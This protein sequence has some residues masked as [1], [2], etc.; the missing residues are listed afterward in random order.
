[1]KWTPIN[2]CGR[3]CV[4]AALTGAMLFSLIPAAA[5]ESYE[6]A[7]PAA[8]RSSAEYVTADWKFG[9]AYTSGSIAGGDLIIEDQSGNEND[10]KMQTYGEGDWS[11]YLSF[12]EESMTGRDGSMVFDGDTGTKTGA[13]F[14]TVDGAP[15]NGETFETGYTIEVLY[16]FPEDWTAAD[17]WMGILARQTDDP[18]SFEGMDEPELGTM[19]MAVSNC[20]EIQ[21][22][23]APA[24]QGHTMSSAAWS[25]TMD[26]GGV[27]YHIAVVSDGHE[28]S[29]YVNGCEAFRDYASDEMA[30]MY[31]DPEDGR[32]RV[33][34]SWWN[35]LDKFL[36]GSLQ[37]IRISSRALDKADWL[38]PNPED[39]LGEFGRND[40]YQLRNEDN[41]NYTNL[42]FYANPIWVSVGE[43]GT[44]D[45]FAAESLTL[46]PGETEASVNLNWYAPAGT[47]SAQVKFGEQVVDAAVSELT[48]PTKVDTA[49][50]TDTGKMACKATVSGLTPETTYQ[51]QISND[52]GATW[53]KVYTYTTAA[54]DS[55]TFA[56]TSDP[57][58]KEDQST[59][60]GG[61]NPAD[62]TNQTGWAVMM[63]TVAEAGASLMVSAGDQ[64][65]DQSWGKS[66]EYAAFFAPEEMTSMLY[67]PAVG[68]HDRHYMFADHFNLPNEMDVAGDGQPGTPSLLEQIKTTFRGQNNGTS[69]SHGN[70][71]QATADEIANHSESNGVTPNAQGF[72]DFTERRAMETRGNYYYLFNNVL[73]VTLNTGA[74]PG[75]NDEENAGNADVPSAGKDNAEAEAMVENFRRTLEAAV[76]EYAGQYDWL[77]VTHH[78]STQTVAKHAA[79]SDIEN[80]VDAGFESLM[81]EFDVDF[82]LGGHDHVYS[83]SYVL[84]DGARNAEALDTFHDPDGTIY[85][86]GNC[87]SDMQYYTPFESLDKTNNADYPI[88]AN[89]ETG[90]QAYLA[91]NLPYG[92]QE[93]NQEYSPSYA[94]FDVDG[95]TISVDVYNL[96]GDSV[97]PES[98]RIDH[99]TVTKNTDGG[100]QAQGFANGGSTLDLT[101][102]GRYEAGETNVDGGVMEIVSYNART[103]WAYAVNGQSGYLTAIALKTLEEKDSVDLL[104]GNDIDVKA[105][106]EAADA[107]FQYGDMTSVAVSPDGSTLAAALQAEGYADA[108]RVA[109]F[110]CNPDGSLTLQKLVP[111]GVQPD[112]VTFAD[113]HT[114]LTADE[115]EPR[116]GYG[117]GIT[118]PK[119]SV[120]I[121][122]T[123]AGTASVVTFDS[124]D[125][126]RDSLA[127][128]GVVLKKNTAPSVDFEPEYLAL[129]GG[130]A[131]VT[132]QEANAIAVLDLS[133]KAF[134]GVYSAGFE[135]YS[136][137]PVDID[138]KDEAYA[139]KTYESLMGIRMP[140]GIAAFEAGGT[141]YL[142]TAN[143]GDARE[144]G[145]EDLGTAYLNEDERNFK[146]G[147]DT[148][149][150]GAITA[151]NSGL[152]GKVVFF[153]VE[154]YDGLDP[155][156]DYLFGGRSFTVYEVAEDGISEV[157]TSG[158][159]FEALTARYLP[160][161]FNSSNDNSALDDRS[162]KKGPEAE[163][164]TVGAVDGHTYAFV[165]LERTGGVMVYDVTDPADVSFVNYINSRNFETIV[166]GSEEYDDGELDK[167]VTGGDVA[168]E[169]LAF[170]PAGQSPNGK[171][172]LLAA[173][174]VSGTVAVYELSANGTDEPGGGSGGG[175]SGGGSGS[176]GNTGGETDIGDEETPL[177]GAPFT[178][179]PEDAWYKEAVDYVYANGLMSGTSATTFAPNMLLSR[180]MIAQ[181]AHNL[182]D[183]PAAAEQGVFTDVAADAWYADAV[184][185]AAGE[186]IVS[187]YGNGEF[188]P[189]DNI[190]REQ[191]ALILYG[192][193]QYKGYDV[194]AGGELSSFTDGASTS[195]WAAEAVRWAVGSGLLSGKGGGVLDPQ[196]TATRAEVASI[197]MRF[198]QKNG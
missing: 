183:N 179:V 59:N 36:Q 155:A 137:T 86:T 40:T 100:D 122:D 78:K 60:S 24:D 104:D 13:D 93:Y 181:V 19:S 46:Q 125:S 95:N 39:Y 64:V 47:V 195:G 75:G 154:D 80:Y 171:D 10:L 34:S 157:F 89:G 81:D 20:K 123:D 116:E 196:G 194:S 82:V 103:G 56:F 180:A 11:E 119:G 126:Q 6:G 118:D 170:L 79:D 99:F 192:Y 140:D 190:T 134:T 149:P 138:K 1:M 70:Y 43:G 63:E 92:N 158:D 26:E 147:E 15:I 115:G 98:K 132:L 112:M 90:S 156:K 18:A 141:T 130:R 114:V 97:N 131:Y 57:Q 143:E 23:T 176:G 109:L 53:S 30:G 127:V 7:A 85:L 83:R 94:L 197:L 72:Y 120:S 108:G 41:Y 44:E 73:F 21:F 152:D 135:D 162:G 186:G 42:S 146:D 27:W 38:I 167:W 191:M 172:L 177:G 121:V 96:S 105:L 49:K 144:W 175:S 4:A 110:A 173:C 54:E 151:E 3:R 153:L 161:Y 133:A 189:E 168:P 150:T 5:A 67:A 71:I 124:F 22:S 28:I 9:R 12:S 55:F 185:W 31:A 101:Q 32:F 66:S 102:T 37:E 88:L 50:Y 160:A 65:E 159:D 187:G 17:A 87:A 198:A 107:S 33:G 69:Q 106:V 184:D 61:W 52:G 178:D 74:Y 62:G 139:P 182:E 111:V 128:A 129:S 25:V 16:Y 8:G 91:G 188:G 145:D 35:G 142:V 51:Y 169:G 148:S 77:I 117:E 76:E 58:I 68:N 14:I 84:K 165:A 29:T 163:S 164:I 48:A 166:P 193:A 2:H 174:E 136:T 113:N 45:G